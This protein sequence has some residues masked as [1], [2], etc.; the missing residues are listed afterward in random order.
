MV[1]VEMKIIVYCRTSA[2]SVKNKLGL[3]DYSYYFILEKYLPVLERLG[4]VVM[5]DEPEQEVDNIYDRARAA[6]EDAVFLSFTPPHSTLVDLR[7]PTVCV[8]AWEFESIPD[9]S[10][11]ADD[12]RQNWVETIRQIGNVITISEYATSVIRRQVGKQVRAETVPAPVA[13][14][15][16]SSLAKTHD[17]LRTAAALKLNASIVDSRQYDIDAE[18]V[19]PR[20]ADL[21]DHARQQSLWDGHAVSWKFTS[22]KARA[23][24]Y[25]V[26]FYKPEEWGCWSRVNKPGILLPWLVHGE[27]EMELQL[28]AYRDTDG[29][30]LQLSVGGQTVELEISTQLETY[31]L[32]FNLREPAS[33]IHFSG[34][35]PVAIPGAWDHRTLGIGLAKIAIRRLGDDSQVVPAAQE[36]GDDLLPSGEAELV[37]DG[38]LYTSVFNPMDGRKNWH[39]IVTA[40]CAAFRDDPSKTLLLKMS[41]HNMATFLGDLLFLFSRLSPFQCRVIAVKGFLDD[42]QF[43]D[44]IRDTHYFVNASTAE[45]QCLPLLEFMAQGVPGI[46]PRHTAMLSYVSNKTAFVVDSSKQ[47]SNW[48]HDPRNAYRTYS[49]R[50]DWES[51]HDALQES[52]RVLEQDPGHYSSM[53]VA[54]KRVVGKYYSEKRVGRVL[55]RFLKKVVKGR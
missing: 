3:P 8:L 13:V 22:R 6:G 26:G 31:T 17:T 28:V 45:G 36:D 50:L 37:F 49:N 55:G 30:P 10:W 43:D 42:T 2:G 1:P 5:V 14:E 18:S 24:Q 12:P 21:P 23:G 27:F 51:L 19:V 25:L 44:L 9:E 32:C 7:C 15:P 47:P 33:S 35:E 11:D 52:A 46:A 48:P 38:A 4:E 41:H 20:L 53:G 29:A 34:I 54:A 16:G 40:F 39:D